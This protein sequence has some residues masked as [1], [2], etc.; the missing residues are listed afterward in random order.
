MGMVL[1]RCWGVVV[2]FHLLTPA[3]SLNVQDTTESTSS[4]TGSITTTGGLGIE[5]KMSV[6][7]TLNVDGAASFGAGLTCSGTFKHGTKVYTASDQT[8]DFTAAISTYSTST[9]VYAASTHY[10]SNGITITGASTGDVCAV[11]PHIT[12]SRRLTESEAQ[13]TRRRLVANAA[14]TIDCTGANSCESQTLACTSDPC[15][16]DCIGDSACKGASITGNGI[17]FVLVV[18]SGSDAC[19]NLSMDHG[20]N[21]SIHW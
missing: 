9:S 12:F 10:R 18:C 17:M 1:C 6:G 20:N 3:F 14:Q 13:E 15:Q 4:S 5:R 8:A 21:D 2:L 16:I 7:G 11:S 19:K